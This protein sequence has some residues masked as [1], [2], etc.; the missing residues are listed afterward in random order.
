M[1]AEQHKKGP[2]RLQLLLI[3]AVFAGPLA[4][5]A[6][7]YYS[8]SSLAPGS[9]TNKGALLLP[10]VSLSEEQPLS[11]LHELAPDQWLMLYSNPAECGDACRDALV[12]LRQ[13]R[14]MLGKDMPR[15][16]R[17]FLHG[18]SAPDTVSLEQQ[19][20][21]L[22]TITDKGLSALLEDKR[23]AGLQSGGCYLIDPLGN[24]V[25]YFP[26]ELNPKDMVGDIKHLLRLSHIG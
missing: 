17:V 5:A 16:V 14:L 18:E 10:I 6:W 11:N 8:G 21:G 3:A 4:L 22:I 20:A 7:M 1:P 13:S 24:L 19:H 9:G 26:P 25:M 23:P 15:V 2:G 12:R